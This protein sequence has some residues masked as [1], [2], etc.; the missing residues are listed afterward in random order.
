[1]E[2]IQTTQIAVLEAFLA[3]L[4]GQLSELNATNSWISDNPPDGFPEEV[5]G[6]IAGVVYPYEGN[7][8]DAEFGGQGP[9]MLIEQTGVTV[10][11]YS[12][13]HLAQ[14]GKPTIGFTHATR[15]VLALKHKLLKIHGHYL[16]NGSGDSLLVQPMQVIH[17][18]RPTVQGEPA[19]SIAVS[20]SLPFH[21]DLS[22]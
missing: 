1:M 4:R 18:D 20:Y 12:R 8:S 13:Q 21:W 10:I 9:E 7:F 3:H 11:I 15:G 19:G 2:A 16:L 5:Q 6:Q 14:K 22:I 17:S